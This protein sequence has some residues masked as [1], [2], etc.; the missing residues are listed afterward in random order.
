[1]GK[2]NLAIFLEEPNLPENSGVFHPLWWGTWPCW[3]RKSLARLMMINVMLKHLLQHLGTHQL[4]YQTLFTSW[5][6]RNC[7]KPPSHRRKKSG[8]SFKK[9]VLFPSRRPKQHFLERAKG[10]FVVELIILRDFQGTVTPQFVT[11]VTEVSECWEWVMKFT[12]FAFW[13]S[14]TRWSQCTVDELKGI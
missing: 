12:Y 1:M 11:G 5:C 3:I 6:S 13:P 8:I 4:S 14:K 9:H 7:S 2:K 10:H